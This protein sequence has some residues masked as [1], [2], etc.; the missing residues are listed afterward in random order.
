MTNND[1]PVLNII[2]NSP[3]RELIKVLK[4]QIR[5]SEEAKFAIGYFFLTGFSLVESDFPDNFDNSPFLVLPESPYPQIGEL[6][7][8]QVL[9]KYLVY[10]WFE[11]RVLNLLKR[12]ILMEF[13]RQ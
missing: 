12:D 6:I 7:D 8:P 3:D 9:F 1:V 10:R 2:D 13:F 5:R 4:D 11:G